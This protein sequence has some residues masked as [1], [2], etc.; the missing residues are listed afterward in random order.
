M[1]VI[2]PVKKNFNSEHTLPINYS[3][4]HRNIILQKQAFWKDLPEILIFLPQ[5]V[6]LI[7]PRPGIIFV[8]N[9]TTKKIVWK[10]HIE[11]KPS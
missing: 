10:V 4:R 7:Y 1:A 6:H 9:T 3:Q 11:P 5:E 8:E 2:V